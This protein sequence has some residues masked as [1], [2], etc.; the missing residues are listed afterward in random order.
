MISNFKVGQTL[1]WVNNEWLNQDRPFLDNGKEVIVEKTGSKW[2]Y[3]SN[4]ERIDIESLQADGGK[5]SSP[6][7]C[8]VDR[9]QYISEMERREKW[10]EFYRLVDHMYTVP[11]HLSTDKISEM[12]QIIRSA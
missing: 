4:R 10:K 3:L 12:I 8:Y 7:R 2:I 1:W 6:G 11:D 9:Q 5:Y